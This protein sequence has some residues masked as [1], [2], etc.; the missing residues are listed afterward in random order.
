MA[1]KLSLLL[2]AIVLTT[3][4]S[5]AETFQID[6]EHTQINFSIKHLVFFTVQGNFKEFSGSIQADPE[7]KILIAAKATIQAT[8]VDTGQEKRDNYLR[9]EDFFDAKQYPEIHFKSKNV[10]GSGNDITMVGDITI[11][12]ITQEIVLRGSFFEITLDPQKKLR[13]KFAATGIINHQDFKLRGDN[14]TKTGKL[15]I[16]D[17]VKIKLNVESVMQ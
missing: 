4:T 8:S 13:A 5:F 12:G 6:P 16:G 3:A 14:P 9:G 11:K 2:L 17:D 15:V 10:T 1:R 7:N